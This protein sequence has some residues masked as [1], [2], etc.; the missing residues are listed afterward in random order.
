MCG[1]L[2]IYNTTHINIYN[3]L[4]RRAAFVQLIDNE[5]HSAHDRG[6]RRRSP[7]RPCLAARSPA[8]AGARGGRCAVCARAAQACRCLT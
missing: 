8:V 7:S 3:I 1:L 5:P 2:G 6:A 4:N